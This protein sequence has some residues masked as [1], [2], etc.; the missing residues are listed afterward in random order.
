M[1]FNYY[2][3]SIEEATNL[4]VK[5]NSSN[6]E[7]KKVIAAL[8]GIKVGTIQM[9]ISNN[10]NILLIDIKD[11]GMFGKAS[12]GV[13][14]VGLEKQERDKSKKEIKKVSDMV[15]KALKSSKINF[16]DLWKEDDIEF[17]SVGGILA[18][19]YN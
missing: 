13:F 17:N 1:E 10:E 19:Y 5:K 16:E 14:N 15:L 11:T 18:D 8:K 7:I 3:E 9:V 6:P 12:R 2:K 4:V